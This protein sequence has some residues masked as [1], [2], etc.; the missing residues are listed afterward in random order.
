MSPGIIPS[1][2]LLLSR[3][4]DNDLLVSDYTR[5]EQALHRLVDEQSG[6]IKVSPGHVITASVIAPPN[7]PDA[8]SMVTQTFTFYALQDGTFRIEYQHVHGS[9]AHAAA[10]RARLR[11]LVYGEPVESCRLGSAHELW[12]NNINID[13]L[14]ASGALQPLVKAAADESTRALQALVKLSCPPNLRFMPH[15]TW[16]MAQVTCAVLQR[17]L[18]DDVQRLLQ[19]CLRSP[20][21]VV[22][23]CVCSLLGNIAWMERSGLIGEFG[24]LRRIVDQ[25][26]VAEDLRRVS[27][28]THK[29]AYVYPQI[30]EALVH[31]MRDI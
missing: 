27:L 19:T 4:T 25:A 6:W 15:S 29:Q 2:F 22:Q 9:R 8:C 11:S 10:F 26:G 31:M 18:W 3:P 7:V 1:T 30:Q 20:V 13:T 24:D 21:P 23:R 16:A 12:S 14:T 17:T 5:V 28:T